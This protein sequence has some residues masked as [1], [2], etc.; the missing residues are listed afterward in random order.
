[1]Q[2]AEGG[3]RYFPGQSGDMTVTGWQLMAVRSGQLAQ[4]RV[5]RESLVRA[6]RF[7]NR[8]ESE[9]GAFYGYMEPG[10]S[11]SPTA[12]GLL[13]RMYNGWPQDDERLAQGVAYLAEL[14]PSRDDMYFNYYAT[15]VLHHYEGRCWDAWNETL[16]E[17][18]IETQSQ[19]EFERGSWYFFDR[20]G[21]QG[22]RHY[23]TAM[24]IM[25]LEV[26]YRYMPLYT[27]SSVDDGTESD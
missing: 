6:T 11:P 9:R 10:K 23:N 13:M 25:I 2:H 14:G 26:Y 1:V 7:L 20:H 12:I 8:M 19:A 18:L 21:A 22:G 16:R 15:Q 17:Y 27:N 4:L 5:P 24:A 3:W